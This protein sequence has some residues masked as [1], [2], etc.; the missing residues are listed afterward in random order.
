MEVARQGEA[1]LLCVGGELRKINGALVSEAKPWEFSPPFVQI[2]LSL[3]PPDWSAEEGCSNTQLFEAEMTR[4]ILARATRKIL[5]ADGTKWRR[6]TIIRCAERSEL[7]DWMTDKPRT[8]KEDRE[9]QVVR[10]RSTYC[11]V[12]HGQR[13]K[14]HPIGLPPSKSILNPALA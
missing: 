2:S 4:A 12:T 8:G 14:V 10:F 7:N 11:S 13:I 6:P 1:E 9:T 3:A 5:L